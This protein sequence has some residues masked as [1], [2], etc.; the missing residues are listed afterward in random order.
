[1]IMPICVRPYPGELLYGWIVRLARLNGYQSVE[2]FCKRYFYQDEPEYEIKPGQLR[3]DYRFNLDKILNQYEGIKCFPDPLAV[4]RNMTTYFTLAPFETLA[5][6]VKRSQKILRSP[7]DNIV[8]RGRLKK[9]ISELHICPECYR[10]DMKK[11]GEPYLHTEHHLHRVSVCPKHHIPLLQVKIPDKIL[12]SKEAY[13]ERCG[14]VT[15]RE[16]FKVRVKIADFMNDLF[17]DPPYTRLKETQLAIRKR[18]EELGYPVRPPYGNL[19]ED[20][21]KS[22][23]WPGDNV[24]DGILKQTTMPGYYVQ[25][26]DIAGLAF[27]L[28]E[29]Y[30]DFRSMLEQPIFEA[31]DQYKGYDILEENYGFLKLRCKACGHIFHIHPY[32]LKMGHIC[33]KCERNLSDAEN[34]N[35]ML[36]CLGDGEYVLDGPPDK[37]KVRI[38]HKPCG[39]VQSRNLNEMIYSEKECRCT[40][41]YSYD[42]IKEKAGDEYLILDL[43]LNNSVS[44][45][46]LQHRICNGIFTLPARSFL[47]KPYCRVCDSERV[48][49]ARFVERMRMLT[50]DDYELSSEYDFQGLIKIKHRLCETETTMTA[51]SFLN[52]CRCGLCYSKHAIKAKD[53]E[54]MILEYAGEGYSVTDNGDYRIKVIDPENKEY[55]KA[56]QFYVQEL[57]RPTPSPVFKDRK[58][59]MPF[60]ISKK[61]SIYLKVKACCEKYQV[62]FLDK[63][64]SNEDYAK[65]KSALDRMVCIDGILYQH[66]TK[67]YSIYPN[68]P[69]EM[70]VEQKFLKR[71]GNQIG[72]YYG[73]S[74]A[75]RCG[76][77]DQAPE[78]DYIISN[79]SVMEGFSDRRVGDTII[80]VRR[81]YVQITNENY[82]IIEALNLLMFVVKLSSY[83][84]KVEDY[85]IKEHIGMDL[86][87][88]YIDLYPETIKKVTKVLFRE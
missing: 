21:L 80:K 86:L 14:E 82:R 74:L 51:S 41:K 77:I 64:E 71:M 30:A 43:F 31:N 67:C 24:S 22:G 70:I 40:V 81:P 66:G 46:K 2:K 25:I 72:T 42:D 69:D 5:R 12:S 18:I 34:I 52:G 65:L 26:E 85:L 35:R 15:A 56:W 57:T 6:Q 54:Q 88:P 13:I 10:D 36:G 29:N 8:D 45:V 11:Y 28:F 37:D 4:L 49:K 78:K 76:I 50:G 16:P 32:A 79:T 47:E 9:D 55:I 39:K 17:R 87:E 73:K 7:T 53:L 60:E 58:G 61:A 83:R 19:A 84:N 62:W 38:L 3:L 44:Y 1:M 68:V 59:I 27:F 33:P 20:I 48:P 63:K 23:F 75:Y